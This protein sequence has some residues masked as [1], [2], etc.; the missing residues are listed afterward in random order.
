MQKLIRLWQRHYNKFRA[1][2]ALIPVS[3]D[4]DLLLLILT[5]SARLLIGP[6]WT[7]C[8]LDGSRTSQLTGRSTFGCRG[9]QYRRTRLL[10]IFKK[11]LVGFDCRVGITKKKI[12]VTERLLKYP[13]KQACYNHGWSRHPRV[14]YAYVCE[15]SW[16]ISHL[17]SYPVKQCYS[18]CWKVCM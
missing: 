1:G 15:A 11:F 13:H 3:I 4:P 2:L 14:D 17:F 7:N 8:G 12:H 9:E 10:W 5:A 6:D 18:C 16:C